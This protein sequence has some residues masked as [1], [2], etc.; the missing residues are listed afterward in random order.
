MI[1][2]TAATGILSS[3]HLEEVQLPDKFEGREGL[4]Q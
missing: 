1:G 2:P 3:T 4:R